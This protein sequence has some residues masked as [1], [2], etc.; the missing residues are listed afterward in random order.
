MDAEWPST[1]AATGKG[2]IVLDADLEKQYKVE[3]VLYD[4]ASYCDFWEGN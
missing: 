3:E 4:D 2:G 1:D